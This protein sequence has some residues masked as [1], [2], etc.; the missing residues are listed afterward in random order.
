MLNKELKL[1][2]RGYFQIIDLSKPIKK[3]VIVPK[4]N[5]INIPKGK[6]DI[7]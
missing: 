6:L 4:V 2:C 1:L 5:G 3:Y 7:K